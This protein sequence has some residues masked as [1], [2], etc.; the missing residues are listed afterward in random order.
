MELPE[1]MSRLNSLQELVL[2]G[3]SNLDSLNM[4]LE[5]HQGRNLLQSDVIIASASYITSL[6][7]KL[8]FPS[9]FSTRKM[10]RFTLF[11]LPRFLESLDLSGTPIR[12][13]PESIRNLGPL[14]HL[15]LRNCKMLQALPELPSHLWL[16]DVS[17]C[18][19]LQRLANP[20]NWTQVEGCDHLVEFQVWMKQ[21]LI[22]KFDSHMFRILE[23][24]RAQIQPSRFQ[25]LPHPFYCF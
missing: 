16:L 7:L 21:E 12:Y 2:G 25:V 15:Y 11:S 4:E 14:R 22:Q 6:P 5:H 3:C 18:N 20:N 17:F 9:R 13:L 19:S 1:E 10:L 24:A 23:T 8:F